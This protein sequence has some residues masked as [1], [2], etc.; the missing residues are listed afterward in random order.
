[1]NAQHA[2]K[3]YRS[4]SV[5]SEITGASSHR[6]VAM[7]LSG[8]VD[9]LAMASN[10]IQRGHISEKGLQISKVISIV[11]SLRA[12]L[13]QQR[14]GEIARNLASLY[15]YIETRL[16]EANVSS[17]LEMIA[18]VSGLLRQLHDGWSQIQSQAEA[19]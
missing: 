12:S 15:D 19:V 11:D 1:M 6:L 4:I 14:G 16:L 9:K 18:E 7:L 3:E 5:Q 17:D 8:A 13:D 2:L 10:A